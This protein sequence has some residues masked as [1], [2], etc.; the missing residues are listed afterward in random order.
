MEPPV[1]AVVVAIALLVFAASFGSWFISQW[2][3][4]RQRTASTMVAVGGAGIVLLIGAAAVTIIAAPTW[5]HSWLPKA[6]FMTADT[7]PAGDAA[8]PLVA[9]DWPEG[10]PGLPPAD[11]STAPRSLSTQRSG[12]DAPARQGRRELRQKSPQHTDALAPQPVPAGDGIVAALSDTPSSGASYISGAAGL[13]PLQ[14]WPATQCVKSSRAG[15]LGRWS[16]DNE[17]R[18]VVAV[19]FA[20]CRPANSVCAANVVNS[21]DWR[22]EPAGILMTTLAQRPSPHRLTKSGPLFAPTYVLKE[23]GDVPQIRYLACPVTGAELLAL[24]NEPPDFASEA[25]RDAAFDEALQADKCYVRVAKWSRMGQR[26]GK[27]LDALLRNGAE[28]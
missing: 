7:L 26:T 17:C 13:D 22:Y 1:S 3:G 11:P 14:D 18:D 20:W 10:L 9:P 4:V 27:S 15:D 25:D 19:V 5:W 12:A 23:S 2:I 21:S 24:L 16:L 8:D 28:P 6:E